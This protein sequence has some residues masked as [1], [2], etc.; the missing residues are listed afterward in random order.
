VTSPALGAAGLAA[1]A[2]IAW[3]LPGWLLARR[4]GLAAGRWW[5][6]APLAFGLGL[7]WLLIP[8]AAGLL[9]GLGVG[10]LVA[11]VLVLN[12]ALLLAHLVRRSPA[13]AAAATGA[14]RVHPALLAVAVLACAALAAA[15]SPTLGFTASGD[16]WT[17]L[18]A[19]RTFLDA[20]AIGDTLDLDA[21][22]LVLAAL[23]RLGRPALLDAYRLLVPPVLL[24]AAVLSFHLLARAVADDADLGALAV[25]L[26]ALHALSDMHTR[27][28]GLGMGLLVRLIE[29]KHLAAFVLVPLA[30]AAAL[31]GL[32]GPDR[33]W[34]AAAAAVSLA[35]VLVH[36]LSAVWLT[37][38]L[39]VTV[40]MGLATGAVARGRLTTALAWGLPAALALVAFGL[41]AL[42]P[43]AYFRLYEPSWPYNASFLRLSRNQLWILS[44]E[45]GWYLA[46]PRLAA[47][48]FVIAAALGA[49]ALLPRARR[50]LGAAF[51]AASALVPLLLAY[52]P[53]TARALG[54]V[55]T[56]WM[57]YRVLWAVPAALVVAWTIHHGLGR[58]VR[59]PRRPLAAGLVV[60]LLAALLGQ[61]MTEARQA[62]Q[63][64]NH[65]RLEPGERAFLDA[66]GR[67]PRPDG[68]LLA[69][70]AL[71]VRLPAFTTRL[72]PYAGL[73]ALRRGDPEPVEEA[74]RLLG[75][76]SLGP[77]QLEALRAQGITHL[78]ARTGARLDRLLRTRAAAFRP[79]WE[80][81]EWTLFAFRQ[82]WSRQ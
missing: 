39:G 54:A 73:D 41:R 79:V 16:D 11:L 7:A 67:E 44:L 58:W 65:V 18:A 32:R 63:E 2:G 8:A 22:D 9:L 38:S 13:A 56:P 55:I 23:V 24:A 80:G 53:L 36:P 27:G 68:V 82:E 31:R 69:P 6:T 33:R 49:L 19:I 40:A 74:E 26:L 28:E 48:P 4:L 15:S 37:L 66:L 51:L 1:A 59:P 75:A 43:A 60:L 71:G 5:E 21:W 35:A 52:N 78:A 61:R 17:Q 70:L 45:D 42:R 77:E 30:Q 72:A 20:P 29:D 57:L 81:E 3:A 12:A 64:R 46:D 34:L 62:A 25:A 10:A 14:G 50:S 47:H 76:R